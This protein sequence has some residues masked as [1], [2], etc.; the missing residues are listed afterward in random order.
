MLRSAPG[1]RDDSMQQSLKQ[2]SAGVAKRMTGR[3]NFN[4]STSSLNSQ[5]SYKSDL[6]SEPEPVETK[7]QHYHHH[8]HG[9]RDTSARLVSQVMDWLH[10]EKAKRSRKLKSKTR[11]KESQPVLDST[12]GNE[13]SESFGSAGRRMSAASDGDLA[14]DKLEQ[15]I[16]ENLKFV[17]VSD[18][19]PTKEHRGFQLPRRGSIVRKLRK[20]STAA[21]SDTD[22]QD[23]DAVVPHTDVVLDNSKTMSYSAGAGGSQE[24]LPASS[25]RA[26][27]EKE[28]WRIFKSEIVR[29]AHTLRLKGWRRVPLD[30]GRDIDV[31]RLSGALTNAVYVVSPP[32]DLPQPTTNTTSSSPSI[33]PKKPPP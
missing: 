10:E 14:L 25:K 4:A 7:Q 17:Q 5:S 28:D 29:I 20:G 32:R 18:Q 11:S 27:R 8:S 6:V 19:T 30:R 26:K 24:E 12:M 23:G 15:I 2:Y 3:P 16:A 13:S 9:H 33:A 1:A 31:E 21:S 22:Y